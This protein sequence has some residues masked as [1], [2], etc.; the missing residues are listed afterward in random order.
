MH[1]EYTTLQHQHTEL[2]IGH[3]EL[4]DA[5]KIFRHG[6]DSGF[7]SVHGLA[8][9]ADDALAQAE[10]RMSQSTSS[11]ASPC[12]SFDNDQQGTARERLASVAPS[13]ALNYY[14]ASFFLCLTLFIGL[15]IIILHS[16]LKIALSGLCSHQSLRPNDENSTIIKKDEELYNG[17]TVMLLYF[18][19]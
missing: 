10:E 13:A 18:F 19:C 17:N 6:V 14:N 5:E 7:K 9:R 8:T 11:R 2:R 1:N 4:N 12:P 3:V 15:S 16:F